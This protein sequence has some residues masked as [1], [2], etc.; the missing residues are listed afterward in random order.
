MYID[1]GFLIL[2]AKMPKVAS[3]AA[4]IQAVST[5]AADTP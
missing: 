1:E 5:Q 4:E 2:S 3:K